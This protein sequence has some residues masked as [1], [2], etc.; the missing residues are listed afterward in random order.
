MFTVDEVIMD[1]KTSFFSYNT[2]S[3]LFLMSDIQI[4]CSRLPEIIN[5]YINSKLIPQE[6]RRMRSTA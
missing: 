2:F 4:T 5:N 3:T 6:D 1:Q